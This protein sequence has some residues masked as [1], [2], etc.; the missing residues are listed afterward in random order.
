M[1]WLAATATS[2]SRP[3]SA[4]ARKAEKAGRRPMLPMNT[5]NATK[6]ASRAQSTFFKRGRSAMSSTAS[7]SPAAASG[8]SSFA[9]QSRHTPPRAA[10][11]AM[12][13]PLPFP[14]GCTAACMASL[15]GKRASRAMAAA[16]SAA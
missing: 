2:T 14:S 8:G 3:A 10:K 6:V 7:V 12:R 9:M 15:L 13:L 1:T 11:R 16:D 5:K 4:P